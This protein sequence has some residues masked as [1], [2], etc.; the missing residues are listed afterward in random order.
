M[1]GGWP[2][3]THQQSR[4]GPIKLGPNSLGFSGRG[5]GDKVEWQPMEDLITPVQAS[6]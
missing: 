3:H 6:C 4:L 1:G 2:L 5:T